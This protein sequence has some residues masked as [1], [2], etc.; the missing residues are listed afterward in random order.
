M[1][2][3]EILIEEFSDHKISIDLNGNLFMISSKGIVM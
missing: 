3:Y 2:I 1:E